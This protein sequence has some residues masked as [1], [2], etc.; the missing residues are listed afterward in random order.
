MERFNVR[1]LTREH[2]GAPVDL[3]VMDLSFISLSLCLPA[4]AKTLEDKCE[5]ICLVK[6][7]FEASPGLVGKHGVIRDQAVHR[8]VL[9]RFFSDCA[10]IGLPVKRFTYSPIKGPK[11]NIEFLAHLERPGSALSDAAVAIEEVVALAHSD[12][13]GRDE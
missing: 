8:E 5:V 6:P 3:A 9:G 10:A 4:I 2:I 11:G 13:K 7:Q 1:Y 12:L